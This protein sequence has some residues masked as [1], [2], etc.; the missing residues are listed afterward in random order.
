MGALAAISA[1]DE[2]IAVDGKRGTEEISRVAEAKAEFLLVGPVAPDTGIAVYRARCGL[3]VGCAHHDDVAADVYRRSE[4]VV[5]DAVACA[6]RILQDPARAVVH[7]NR[8]GAMLR[9]RSSSADHGGVLIQGNRRAKFAEQRSGA[10]RLLQAPRHAVVVV[11]VREV[12]ARGA[13]DRRAAEHI[14]IAPET[15]ARRTADELGLLRPGRAETLEQI[16]RALV[17]RTFAGRADDERITAQRNAVAELIVGLHVAALEHGLQRPVVGTGDGSEH[18]YGAAVVVIACRND[19]RIAVD[20]DTR[21]GL[22]RAHQ[23]GHEQVISYRRPVRPALAIVVDLVRFGSRVARADDHEAFADVAPALAEMQIGVGIRAHLQRRRAGVVEE[24]LEALQE[25]FCRVV[26][27]RSTVPAG[28]ADDHALAVDGDRLVAAE[29]RPGWRKER[30]AGCGAI[31]EE[32]LHGAVAVE[33]PAGEEL[34]A[35]VRGDFRTEAAARNIKVARGAQRRV[36][37]A[38]D[39]GVPV[40]IIAGG[41]L[42]SRHARFARRADEHRVADN[43][44]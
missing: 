19:S 35:A 38:A 15:G 14:H 30:R 34:G 13:R 37:H 20:G 4:A 32:L 1:D 43:I 3:L 28:R 2:F 6:D 12:C 25:G 16:H 21:S 9:E 11:Q 42:I 23:F 17:R 41:E 31:T 7:V 40:R 10:Q 33:R 26:Q 22:A 5:A 24:R 8:Y 27:M 18:E 36:V 29:L 44:D 39:G